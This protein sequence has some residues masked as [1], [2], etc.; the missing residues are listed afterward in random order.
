MDLPRGCP[1]VADSLCYGCSTGTV[2]VIDLT[3]AVGGSIGLRSRGYSSC[4]NGD[5]TRQ[6]TFFHAE[7]TVK[8]E[9]VG[10]NRDD[11]SSLGIS[12]SHANTS[13]NFA[14]TDG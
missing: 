11:F 8:F 12:A 13:N 2:S 7:M 6:M 3:G 1:E 4:G 14:R 9:K 5:E 10:F